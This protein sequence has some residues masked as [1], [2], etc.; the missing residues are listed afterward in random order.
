MGHNKSIETFETMFICA[1]ENHDGLLSW[2]EFS[3]FFRYLQKVD[4][5]SADDADVDAVTTARPRTRNQSSV[6][7]A[8]RSVLITNLPS[9][10]GRIKCLALSEQRN[11]YATCHRNDKVVHVYDAYGNA[12]RLLHGHKE[13][14]LGIA[15][16]ND[17]KIVGTVSR[18]RMLM[19]W[20]ATVGHEVS[21][22]SH[23]GIATAIAFSSDGKFVY[24]GCQDNLVRR[25]AC[26][27]CKIKAT[28]DRLP[29]S[30]LGVIVALATQKQGS[31]HIVFSR[32]CDKGAI[33]ADA[34]TLKVM[35]VLEG[36]KSMVWQAHFK[37][38]DTR[39]LTTC[40]KLVKVWSTR[41]YACIYSLD[42]EQFSQDPC[43]ARKAGRLSLW[44]TAL[45]APP[46]LGPLIVCFATDT[47]MLVVDH[48]TGKLM[49]S[50]NT[51]SA[52]Y[53]ACVGEYS[54]ILICGDDWGNVYRFEFR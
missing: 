17:R 18:D 30:E 49:L 28:L 36:H 44:T 12:V 11:L 34:T 1:D 26:S 54:P 10:A 5:V 46:Q 7:V 52:V 2:D 48:D 14:M 6:H 3:K 4:F 32:S 53:S 20:D 23:P 41:D 13:S 27:K 43:I 16:S 9:E 38:D 42:V 21:S 45:F 25:F 50:H 47:T 40:E 31:K 33:V 19:L 29:R 24:T 39:V 15:F 8:L 51:R 35:A 22:V 37:S